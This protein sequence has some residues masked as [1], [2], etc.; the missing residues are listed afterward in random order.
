MRSMVQPE[1]IRCLNE[2]PRLSSGRYVLY[3]M[4]AA[5]RTHWNQ[6]LEFAI[7]EANALGKPVLV[8]FCL[9][10]DFPCANLRH[11]TF[12]LQG[13]QETRRALE[14]RGLQ[15]VIVPG[16]PGEQVVD[17]A[18]D[19]ALVVVD[20]G[21]LHVQRAWRTEVSQRLSC[22]VFEV[23][24]NLIVPV[25][26]AS[27]KAEFSAATF[28]PRI[29]RA[30]GS[31]LQPI[32]QARCRRDSLGLRP[33]GL[34]FDSVDTVLAALG[35]DRSVGPVPGPVGGTSPAKARLKRFLAHKLERFAE[36]RNDPTADCTSDLSP[37][38]H[39]GQISPLYVALQV[40]ATD[41]PGREAFLEELIVRRE[42]ASNFVYYND[43]YDQ[44][45]G[46]APWA[47]RTLD[48]NA[49]ERR[50]YVYN[51]QQFEQAATHDPYWNAAQLEMVLT[52][53][54]H[55]Y[56]RMYWGKKILEWSRTPQRAFQT[57]L[58]LNDKYELDGRD[59]N[60]YA[61]VAWCFGQHDRPWPRHPV[62]GQVRCMNATGLHRKFDPDAYVEKI[63]Q[64]SGGGQQLVQ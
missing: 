53:K 50:P 40:A 47:R 42:L 45:E 5:Q 23:E 62:F 43:R 64:L 29:H 3:W 13:L 8:L 58:C 49:R 30:L 10:D 25:W 17:V 35:I 4:Q 34:V 51:L 15:M 37:Y 27:D 38:L 41:S 24:A 19:A 12:M 56:M 55:G 44:Y 54:M 36:L 11:Y 32:K 48:D 63:R 6:A 22:P 21:L 46:L 60:G 61:G 59:P 57:A 14:Q 7:A 2:R 33:P 16:P 52:G 31:Y 39:F 26:A 28:R 1:R 9:V 20:A 18:R